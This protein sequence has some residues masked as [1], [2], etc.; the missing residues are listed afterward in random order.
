MSDFGTAAV[1]LTDSIL[2]RWLLLLAAICALLSLALRALYRLD[3]ALEE[4]R[5]VRDLNKYR[6]HVAHAAAQEAR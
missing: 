4:R 2:V 5:R 6:A 3:R 1:A